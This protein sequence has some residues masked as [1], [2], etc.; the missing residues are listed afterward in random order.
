MVQWLSMLFAA[1]V[2]AK[3]SLCVT[4]QRHRLLEVLLSEVRHVFPQISYE[5]DANS[6]T[7]NAQALARGDARAV[8]LYGGLAL[9]PLIGEDALIFALLHETGHHFARGRRFALDPMLACECAADKWALTKGSGKWQKSF[10]RRFSIRSAAD[11]LGAVITSV[12]GKSLLIGNRPKRRTTSC[13]A[14]S[15]ETRKTCLCKAQY[16]HLAKNCHR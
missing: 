12:H 1:S 6:R 8:R 5:L 13:W 16:G 15:W 11:Q 3:T 7:A 2:P 4:Q 9:H 14:A 10:G